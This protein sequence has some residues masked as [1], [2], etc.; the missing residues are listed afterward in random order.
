MHGLDL[1]LEIGNERI[2]A[3]RC[4]YHEVTATARVHTSFKTAL[5]HPESPALQQEPIAADGSTPHTSAA[6]D[7]GWQDESCSGQECHRRA[8][9]RHRRHRRHARHAARYAVTDHDPSLT[10]ICSLARRG[11]HTICSSVKPLLSIRPSLPIDDSHATFGSGCAESAV[12]DAETRLS[13]RS[14]A[15]DQLL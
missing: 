1:V 15:F 13:S 11:A 4:A 8:H 2:D 9:R 6:P 14:I 5:L 3:A 10:W 12:S 7:R